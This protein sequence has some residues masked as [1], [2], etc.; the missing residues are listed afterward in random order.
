MNDN[1]PDM[2]NYEK[3]VIEFVEKLIKVQEKLIPDFRKSFEANTLLEKQREIFVSSFMRLTV[4]VFCN[5]S[6][7]CWC[8][9]LGSVWGWGTLH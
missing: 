6:F 3:E 9:E 5:T 7:F 2:S 4:T 8:E 1:D